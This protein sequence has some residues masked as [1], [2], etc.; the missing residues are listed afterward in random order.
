MRIV[1]I[2]IDYSD[3]GHNAMHVVNEY[4]ITL[5]TLYWT[6]FLKHL[7]EFVSQQAETDAMIVN[8]S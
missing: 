7:I 4:V 1:L 2:S 5:I 3:F 6:C 8:V